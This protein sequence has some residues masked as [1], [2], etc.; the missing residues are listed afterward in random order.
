M[1]TDLLRA[2]RLNRRL[3]QWE[4]AQRAS[5]SA[6]TYGRVELGRRVPTAEERR[7]IAE[8]LGVQD[9]QLLFRDGL[10]DA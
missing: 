7:R 6:S 1:R 2:V 9:E 8:A 10:R 4:V 5:L 3:S